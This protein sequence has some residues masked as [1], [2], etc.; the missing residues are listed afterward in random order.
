M[1]SLVENRSGAPAILA[2]M[3]SVMYMYFIREQKE[4]TR[5]REH[6]A[7]TRA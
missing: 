4:G 5:R 2:T 7:E 6:V 3:Q 1:Q